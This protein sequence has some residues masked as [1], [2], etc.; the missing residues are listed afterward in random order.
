MNDGKEIYEELRDS[1]K[2]L[3]KLMQEGL[4]LSPRPYLQ[5]AQETEM[6]EE[7]VLERVQYFKDK[8]L[9]RRFGGVFNS[10]KLG[11]KGIL[12]AAKVK[13]SRFNEVVEIINSHP[14]VTHNYKRRDEYNLWF[15]LSVGPEDDL[16]EE[17]KS[18]ERKTN[19]EFMRISS[20]KKYKLALKLDL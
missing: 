16:E 5:L 6:S 18:L 7:E 8:G 9:L 14:G 3:L 15:T 10:R 1:D 2:R 17:I 13:E 20:R 19:L 4:P 11:Y 12:L